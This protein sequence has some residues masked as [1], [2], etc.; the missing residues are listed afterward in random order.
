MRARML[1]M[2][3]ICLTRFGLPLALL[4]WLSQG[5]A[6]GQDW[7]QWMGPNRDNVWAA[8]GILEEFPQGGP[9]IVW[10]SPVKFGYSGPA[11]VGDRVYLTEFATTDNVGIANFERKSVEGTEAVRCLDA[12][13]GKE[14][15]KQEFPTTYAISYPN[16][17][18]ATPLVEDDRVYTLGAEGRL[19]CFARDSGKIIWQRDLKSE[20]KTNSPLWGY[21][22]HPTIDGDRLIVIAGGEG[23]QTVALDKMT[24]KEIWRY[25][26]ASEQGY[27]PVKFITQQGKRQMLVTSPDWI[28]AIDPQT[29]KEI[30]KESY[31]ADNGSIIMTPLFIQD[32]FVMVGGFNQRS[33]LLELNSGAIGAKPLLRDKPKQLIS[34]VNVQ[35]FVVGDVVY[36]VDASGSLMAVEIPSGKRL[37]ETSQPI[38]E[39]PNQSGTAFIVQNQDRFFLFTENGEL[40]ICKLSRQGYSEI[41][42][43]KVIEPSPGAVNRPV[44]WS[45]PAFAGTRMYVRNNQE[46]VCVELKK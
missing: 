2:S 6:Y 34:P 1:Q 35:P 44:V 23:S 25:G 39:R 40:V 9:T 37:W 20:Y 28:A 4:M 13:T 19:I 29:G 36:G 26:S 42:R 43:A 14:L 45:M 5:L 12:G 46:L 32:R 24:G 38:S 8:K 31:Q 11:V 21:S 41:D 15:W 16:G 3:L 10:R 17:P 22:A 27:C 30:W 18:R 33:L 7:P